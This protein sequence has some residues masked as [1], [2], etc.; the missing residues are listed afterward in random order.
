HVQVRVPQPLYPR[1]LALNHKPPLP[2]T[3]ESAAIDRL[4]E[5]PGVRGNTDFGGQQFTSFKL[6]NYSVYRKSRWVN[7]NGAQIPAQFSN[8]FAALH[9]L[10]MSPAKEPYLFD[11]ILS[12]GTHSFYVQRVP[13]LTLSIGAYGDTELHTVGKDLWI[14]SMAAEQY[15]TVDV[16]YRLAEPASE[17]RRFHETFLWKANF[18]KH[19]VDFLMAKERVHLR[20]FR[21][22]FYNWIFNLHGHDPAFQQWLAEYGR[23]DFRQVF[24]ADPQYLFREATDLDATSEDPEVIPT[25]LLHPV[26]SEVLPRQLNA[27]RVQPIKEEKT[28][29]TPFVWENFKHCGWSCHLKTMKV[30]GTI[31][32]TAKSANRLPADYRLFRS[33][34]VKSTL[35]SQRSTVGVTASAKLHVIQPGDVVKVESGD[36]GW[37]SKVPYWYAFVQEVVVMQRE[38]KLRVIWLNSPSDTGCS[39]GH[40]SHPNELF[41]SHICNCRGGL[42]SVNEVIGISSVAFFG[43]PDEIE[44]EFFVRQKYVHDGEQNAFVSLKISD[45][46][47]NCNA[48]NSGQSY[49]TGDTVL[50]N[51]VES[52]EE[53][54]EPVEIIGNVEKGTK[55]SVRVRRLPRRRRD[56][57]ADDAPPNELIYT[58]RIESIPHEDIVRPCHIRIVR[59][60][61]NE[62]HAIPVPYSRGGTGDAY[63]VH[64]QENVSGGLTPLGSNWSLSLRQGPD[65]G[66]ESRKSGMKCLDLFCG[67]GSFARGIEEGG[68]VQTKWAVDISSKAMHSYSANMHNSNDVHLFSGSVNDYLAQAMRGVG[69]PIVAKRG[70]VDVILAG[71]PCQGFSIANKFSAST[72]SLRNS[73][74]VAA[75]VTAVD[76]YRPKYALMENVPALAKQSKDG[77]VLSQ[78]I[79]T[80]AAMGYQS[81][82]SH[83]DAWSYGSPQS[84][85]RLFISIAAPGLTPLPIP[86]PTHQHPP[87]VRNRKLGV[88]A[89]GLSFGNRTFE[90]TP[91]KAIS[92]GEATADL[93]YNPDARVDSI[94]FPDH[95]VS[96]NQ[97]VIG[98]LRMQSIPRYPRS[99]TY[100]SA[101]QAGRV[102]KWLLDNDVFWQHE[103]RSGKDSKSWQRVNPNRLLP[104]V[105]TKSSPAD[106]RSGA[107]VHWDAPMRCITVQEARRGQG[108]PDDEVLVGL[109]ADQYHAVG[110]GVDRHVALAWG[111]SFWTAHQANK[112]LAHKAIAMPDAV[113]RKYEVDGKP[114]ALNQTANLVKGR[115]PFEKRASLFAK[116]PI[117]STSAD[118]LGNHM[119]TQNL[120]QISKITKPES[121]FKQLAV[122]T[123]SISSGSDTKSGTSGYETPSIIKDDLS[124]VRE[125]VRS[126]TKIT[127]ETEKLYVPRSTPSKTNFKRGIRMSR[128]SQQTSVTNIRRGRM[129]GI[130]Q[131][132]AIELD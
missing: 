37:K 43:Q 2:V 98:L 107:A 49:S 81:N 27:I 14:K 90:P 12:N 100:V 52:L 56:F 99:Q 127:T 83:I 7:R 89:S 1:S 70:E 125:V 6:V 20:M 126:E 106:A 116:R 121:N 29:V 19:V 101:H 59:P 86:A 35:L 71:S 16:W 82:V 22:E 17:Y 44:S 63:F 33:R 47:C 65:F 103:E 24:A 41:L 93:P 13:F 66:T 18:A 108:I 85:S 75:V 124:F 123:T 26:W 11:G 88:G 111:L 58:E 102:H 21:S 110:N 115:V 55:H 42:L 117:S 76:Y 80:F 5:L 9:D 92:I 119:S 45:F 3:K 25:L 130:S 23:K 79:C 131:D 57:G 109:P 105:M 10:S 87:E 46:E 32:D 64:Y 53:I 51:F 36:I 104:T 114:D 78:L 50:V 91:F 39:D 132:V 118:E 61:E 38:E 95:R 28:I 77:C 84:R 113:S 30:S 74:L 54:L 8:E 128:A 31:K 69:G 60:K 15:K 96:I 120:K 40:Y 72:E 68:A 97:S 67:A 94:P 129:A 73:S 48:S 34:T 112:N 122:D 62:N 4:L